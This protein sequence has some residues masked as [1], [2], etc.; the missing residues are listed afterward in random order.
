MAAVYVKLSELTGWG[1][2]RR[3]WMG[4]PDLDQLPAAVLF[5]GGETAQD[6]VTCRLQVESDATIDVVCRAAEAD[7]IGAELSNRI[8]EIKALLMADETLGGVL[9]RIRY[10][11]CDEP[12]LDDQDGGSPVAATTLTFALL[13]EHAE[14][15]PYT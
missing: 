9:S 1:L 13:Y 11:G 8:A 6:F 5:D 15:S 12:V 3:N 7:D 4:T 10:R 2:V 14:D